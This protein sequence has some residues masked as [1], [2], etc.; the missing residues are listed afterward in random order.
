[1]NRRSFLA[2]LPLKARLWCISA[3]RY[4]SWSGWLIRVAWLQVS[5]RPSPSPFWRLRR[6]AYGGWEALLGHL[7]IGIRPLPRHEPGA[8]S[9]PLPWLLPASLA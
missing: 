7:D 1:M 8:P 5:W 2:A 4:G 3:W 6:S 9:R